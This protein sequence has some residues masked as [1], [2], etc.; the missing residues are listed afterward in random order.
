MG[1]MKIVYRKG[2]ENDSNALSRREDYEDLT[3][4][5]IRIIDKPILEKKFEEYDA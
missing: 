3:K 2:S 4:E 5:S 1:Y